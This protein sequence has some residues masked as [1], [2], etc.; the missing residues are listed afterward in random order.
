MRAPS[1]ETSVHSTESGTESGRPPRRRGALGLLS[2]QACLALAVLVLGFSTYAAVLQSPHPDAYRSASVLSG[3]WWTHPFEWNP[4]GRLPTIGRDLRDVYAVPDTNTVYAVGDLGAVLVSEDGGQTWQAAADRTPTPTPTPAASP[5]PAASPTASPAGNGNANNTNANAGNANAG[6]TNAGN[7]NGNMSTSSNKRSGKL[8]GGA[9]SGKGVLGVLL[10]LLDV[11]PAVSAAGL[12]TSAAR[13]PVPQAPGGVQVPTPSPT[14]KPTPVATPKPKPTYPPKP[15]PKPTYPPKPKPKP[16][17]SPTPPPTNNPGVA[18]VENY[19]TPSVKGKTL[20]AVR[21]HNEREGLVVN[22]AGECLETFDGGI[23]WSACEL[24][25]F[26][27]G[28][29][30]VTTRVPSRPFVPPPGAPRGFVWVASEVNRGL[31][32]IRA[33]DVDSV[34]L[35]EITRKLFEGK[36]PVLPPRAAEVFFVDKN[37]A[38]AVGGNERYHSL[39]GG[40]TWETTSAG[41]SPGS[42]LRSLFFIDKSRGWAVGDRGEIVGTTDGGDSWTRQGPGVTEQDLKAVSFLPGGLRGWAVGDGGT[43]LHTEDGGA[44]W[45]HQTRARP[46]QAGAGA[47]KAAAGGGYYLRLLP[48][49]YYLSWV[50]VA[51][52]LLPVRRTAVL[53][54]GKEPEPS[55]AD[56]LVSDRPLE[57]GDRDTI[58]FKAIALGLSRFLRNENTKPP[59]TIAITGEWGTGKSSLM[60]LLRAD[61]RRYDF[62]PVWFNAWHHQKEEHLLAS[63]LQNVRL[64]AIPPFWRPEGI[65]F[66]LRLLV[67][68]GARHW[69]PVLLLVIFAAVAVFYELIRQTPDTYLAHGFKGVGALF[70]AGGALEV[71]AWTKEYLSRLPLLVS[72]LTLAGTIWRGATAFGVKPASLLASMSR[73]VR[74]RDLDAQTSFRQRFAAEFNDVT[75]ALGARSMLVFIDDLDRCR[76]ENVVETLEAVNFLVTSGECFVVIGMARERVEP[77]VGL[78]FK[79]VA[80]EMRDEHPARG[81]GGDDARP[82]K[83]PGGQ[84]PEDGEAQK[85]SPEVQERLKRL[86]EE[87]ARDKR[88]EYARQYLDKLINIEVPVPVPNAKQSCAILLANARRDEEPGAAVRRSRWRRLVSTGAE[89]LARDYGLLLLWLA[90][91]ALLLSACYGLAT[92][93]ARPVAVG[94]GAASPQATTSP[95]P[96]PSPTPTPTPT[97]VPGGV[98]SLPVP[99]PQP[100]P[101]AAPSPTPADVEE[102]TPGKSSVVLVAV[103]VLLVVLTV[104]WVGFWVLTRRPG[105]VV[106]DSPKFV[107]ALEV[108]HPLVF[109]KSSTPRAVKRFMNRV[110]YLAM[111]QR[112]QDDSPPAWQRLLNHFSPPGEG[113]DVAG[114]NKT[115][116]NDKPPIP[117]ELLVALAAIEHFKPRWFESDEALTWPPG[118]SENPLLRLVIPVGEDEEELKMFQK[119]KFMHAEEFGGW[120]AARV[121]KARRQFLG[122]AEDVQVN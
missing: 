65:V 107:M 43:V 89:T 40:V 59:L 75:R 98:V 60:N 35:F 6:N 44:T 96:S 85:P 18:Q 5:S 114:A 61:L 80:A 3:D 54:L 64:Q 33:Y 53:D 97:P 25:S 29:F 28:K 73:G 79:D 17:V 105:L 87:R 57:E 19:P 95:T 11:T 10:G 81:R 42:A 100:T 63:L 51:F 49:W 115:V 92:L 104:L 76:P 72:L 120:D 86:Q 22:D 15:K 67:I 117:D 30:A 39:N 31:L 55:V 16:T 47:G 111:R 119:A 48:P 2:P 118:T 103:P 108:W 9:G 93:L 70:S 13:E 113:G 110:R 41:L 7:T 112:R 14:A 56:V 52:L 90:G 34:S 71:S 83:D 62:R 45:V 122:Q 106:K 84:R 68:R 121:I 78:S 12:D 74:V 77:C 36:S 38:W 20:S 94:G 82:Q 1:E 23:S 32:R 101:T 58:D 26:S 4:P 116:G 37:E 21:L 91:L 69:G 102:L 66:R 88:F 24:R 99:A 27:T 109:A 8:N 50:V 46:R